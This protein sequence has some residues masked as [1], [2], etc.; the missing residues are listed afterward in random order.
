MLYIKKKIFTLKTKNNTLFSRLKL[1]E[2][3]Q[4]NEEKLKTC[5]ILNHLF[6][7]EDIY[8]IVTVI[9][10]IFS[11]LSFLILFIKKLELVLRFTPFIIVFVLEM[12]KDVDY[13]PEDNGPTQRNNGTTEEVKSK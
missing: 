13:E 12:Y 2:S 11:S 9:A 1:S 4:D 10:L 5:N 8:H 3:F 6:I 7:M